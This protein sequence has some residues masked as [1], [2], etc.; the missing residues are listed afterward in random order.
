M[1]L[2]SRVPPSWASPRRW[3]DVDLFRRITTRSV[4]ALILTGTYAY[5]GITFEDLENTRKQSPNVFVPALAMATRRPSN[6]CL[7]F[8]R[9][10]RQDSQNWG[11]GESL[12]SGCHR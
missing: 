4:K 2:V 10:S 1:P 8:C 9:C 3:T 7:D 11:S 5:S 6:K 12:L